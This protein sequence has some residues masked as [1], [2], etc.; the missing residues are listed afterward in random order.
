MTVQHCIPRSPPP[1][2]PSDACVCV[3]MEGKYKEGRMN[4]ELT[5]LELPSTCTSLETPGQQ[6]PS[7]GE[8][9]R[10]TV[11]GCLLVGEGLNSEGNIFS[12]LK[13]L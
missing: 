6:C 13:S 2:I 3:D 11:D 8:T 1:E 5:E 9:E 10:T 12:P 4:P 7:N